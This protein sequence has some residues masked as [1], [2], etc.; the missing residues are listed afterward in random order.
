[1]VSEHELV[2]E[3]RSR[4]LTW[5][6]VGHTGLERLYKSEK[7]SLSKGVA[8]PPW[9][10]GIQTPNLRSQ[11]LGRLVAKSGPSLSLSIPCLQ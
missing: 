8:S 1:M 6:Q 3:G 11:K 7:D 5:G 10:V 4:Q 9:T 2:V